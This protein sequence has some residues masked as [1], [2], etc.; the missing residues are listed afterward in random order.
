[1]SASLSHA[2]APPR[3]INSLEFLLV[4]QPVPTP[5]NS[6][7]QTR[8]LRFERVADDHVRLTDQVEIHGGL[9]QIYADQVD[10]FTDE[11]RLV[12]TGNVVFISAD[13]RIAAERVEF[14]TETETGT[15]FNVAVK[16][17]QANP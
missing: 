11:S 3:L 6:Q 5:I 13:G 10:I 1:M 17:T 14:D 15:F 9:W 4:N 12:A 7:P 8:A 16:G 2:Q